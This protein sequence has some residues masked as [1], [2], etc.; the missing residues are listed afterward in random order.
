M[1]DDTVEEAAEE[2]GL[3]GD[4]RLSGEEEE[5]EGEEVEEEE[6]EVEEE[7]EPAAACWNYADHLNPLSVA[8]RFQLVQHELAKTN[9]YIELGSASTEES[10]D[11]S[12]LLDG[13]AYKDLFSNKGLGPLRDSP[14]HN[15]FQGPSAGGWG[16]VIQIVDG[17]IEVHFSKKSS[18][19]HG[20]KSYKIHEPFELVLDSTLAEPGSV[21]NCAVA[22]LDSYFMLIRFAPNS[23]VVVE[24]ALVGVFDAC[25]MVT[26]QVWQCNVFWCTKWIVSSDHVT[27]QPLPTTGVRAPAGEGGEHR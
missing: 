2:K 8:A 27:H 18:S 13:K 17:S 21:R 23:T 3:S 1:P 10:F 11:L 14:E 16:L 4:E 19:R 20:T 6:E 15:K 12:E 26:V 24:S 9:V 22:Y 25:W 7:E 5:E